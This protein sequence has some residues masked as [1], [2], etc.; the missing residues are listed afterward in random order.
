MSVSKAAADVAV[1]I[2]GKTTSAEVNA[3]RLAYY[4]SGTRS[5]TWNVFFG[6]FLFWRAWV[7]ES[8]KRTIQSALVQ[9]GEQFGGVQ[10][11]RLEDLIERL[12]DDL[13]QKARHNEW[14]IERGEAARTR[15]ESTRW[16]TETDWQAA[17]PLTELA[18]F[19]HSHERYAEALALYRKALWFARRARMHEQF[20][21]FVIWWLC[22][23]VNHCK[24]TIPTSPEPPWYPGPRYPQP[25]SLTP[26][27]L[28]LVYEQFKPN[29]L[30]LLK[31]M[32]LHSKSRSP[33][34]HGII[35]G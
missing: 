1:N 16:E 35:G 25:E 20:R 21:Q 34:T 27:L 2:C 22:L 19:Y 17:A 32:A 7:L 12:R 8:S 3:L 9:Y 10:R 33:R 11:Q 23:E 14:L 5:K 4:E 18:R 15:I 24:Q 30:A 6:L 26:E 13:A 29:S 28:S 31:C